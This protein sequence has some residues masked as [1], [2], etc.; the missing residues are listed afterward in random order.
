MEHTKHLW[1]AMLILLLVGAGVVVGRQFL[2]P[3]SF[4]E[5]GHYRYDSLEEYRALPARHGGSESCRACHKD[6]QFKAEEQGK[7]A[8]VS[9]EACHGPLSFHAA[10]GKKIAD[11]PKNATWKQCLICHERLPSRPKNHP[12]ITIQEHF[13]KQEV[14]LKDPNKVP[15]KVCFKCHD[16]HSP[17]PSE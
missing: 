15:D 13:E 12:Q 17:K 11:A 7:H 8:A 6:D 14:P 9:C 1:R 5:A 16:P 10:D 4:G 3:K 2:I